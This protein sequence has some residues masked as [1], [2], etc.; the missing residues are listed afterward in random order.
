MR[1][2]RTWLS[3]LVAIGLLI[4]PSLASSAPFKS[5]RILAV[6]AIPDVSVF[7]GWVVINKGVKH[8]WC[9]FDLD[10]ITGGGSVQLTLLGCLPD[11]VVADGCDNATDGVIWAL[12]TSLNAAGTDR[13]MV[14]PFAPVGDE[15]TMS[16]VELVMPVPPVWGIH[17]VET[18]STTLTYTI[19]CMWW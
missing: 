2:Y 1:S 3:L 4:V 11:E 10:T 12:G 16:D 5:K 13:V 6:D 17:M 7:G 18:G 9:D 19:N 14:M 8:L 15:A